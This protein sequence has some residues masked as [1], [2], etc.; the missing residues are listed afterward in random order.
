[1][2]VGEG[3]KENKIDE[4]STTL[5]TEKLHLFSLKRFCLPTIRWLQF[6]VTLVEKPK[7]ISE[8][9]EKIRLRI[10]VPL[11]R[12][13]SC[14]CL[15]SNQLE[16]TSSHYYITKVWKLLITWARKRQSMFGEKNCW[17]KE[18][19]LIWH[20]IR[21]GNFSPI[22]LKMNQ[23]C[24]ENVSMGCFRSSLKPLQRVSYNSFIRER[25][26]FGFDLIVQQKITNR[27]RI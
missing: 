6:P 19:D 9:L 5:Q 22:I 14:I 12:Q 17:F 13:R 18:Y 26:S 1:M 24:D 10:A 8:I 4:C 11:F 20:L 15:L 27:E 23:I 3:W 2:L 21:G 7:L 25:I 16:I